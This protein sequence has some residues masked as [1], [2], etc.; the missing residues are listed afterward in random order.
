MIINEEK[1]F[2][3]LSLTCVVSYQTIS[4]AVVRYVNSNNAVNLLNDQ[5]KDVRNLLTDLRLC[6]RQGICP[7]ADIQLS[8]WR[9]DSLI[10]KRSQ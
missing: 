3:L 1:T 10:S 6:L 9:S 7:N 2:Q 8:E 4:L 5:T